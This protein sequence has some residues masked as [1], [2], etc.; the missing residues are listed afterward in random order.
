VFA[1]MRGTL[2]TVGTLAEFLGKSG[3]FSGCLR[4]PSGTVEANAECRSGVR[5][6]ESGFRSQ[7]SET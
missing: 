4:V 2:G 7:E 3:G 5:D 1:K 6:Q